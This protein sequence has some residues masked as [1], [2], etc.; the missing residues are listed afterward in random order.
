MS[1][2]LS[3]SLSPAGVLYMNKARCE[4]HSAPSTP[5]PDS[6]RE[7]PPAVQ[8]AIDF[9]SRLDAAIDKSSAL[10]AEA[11]SQ[12]AAPCVA[13]DE[14]TPEEIAELEREAEWDRTYAKAAAINDARLTRNDDLFHEVMG[15]I[16]ECEDNGIPI[17]HDLTV[18]DAPDVSLD[19]LAIPDDIKTWIRESKKHI[20][21]PT[22]YPS[23]ALEVL[24]RINEYPSVRRKPERKAR[25][26]GKGWSGAFAKL[27]LGATEGFAAHNADVWQS[28]LE[29]MYF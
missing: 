27:F 1:D 11:K 9:N 24:R 17:P 21:P 20:P 28:H 23:K 18:P 13:P 5:T 3:Q 12:L 19:D 7:H 22:P 2:T 10:L 26:Q 6:R 25:G 14:L 4:A 15:L 16:D 8:K 29:T